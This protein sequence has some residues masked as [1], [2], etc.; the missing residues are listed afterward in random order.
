MASPAGILETSLRKG[1]V[2]VAGAGVPGIDPGRVTCPK[3]MPIVAAAVFGGV[4]IGTG[5][6]TPDSRCPWHGAYRSA[7]LY[8]YSCGRANHFQSLERNCCWDIN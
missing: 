2:G 7:W 1:V 5:R 4:T 3:S 8:R 6:G